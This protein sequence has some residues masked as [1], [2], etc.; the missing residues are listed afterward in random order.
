MTPTPQ[1]LLVFLHGHGSSASEAS[2]RVGALELDRTWHVLCPATPGHGPDDE[3]SWFDT[4]AGGVD[5]A[6][7]KSS[8]E[9]LDRLIGGVCSDGGIDGSDVVVGG[10]SQGA[11]M[12][13]GLAAFGTVRPR[14]MVTA[15]GWIP[16][17]RGVEVDLTA[18]GVDSVLVQVSE[19]DEVVPADLSRWSAQAMVDH[20]IAV[21][22][23]EYAGGHRWTADMV[24]D[25]GRWLQSDRAE[26]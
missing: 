1:R 9:H 14:R 23:R 13:I 11:A 24:G 2:D 12:A 18:M 4:A 15:S 21:E 25:A 26:D 3:G 6:T 8:V 20:G 22:V 7:F 17:G 19:G 5:K 10:F 16:E